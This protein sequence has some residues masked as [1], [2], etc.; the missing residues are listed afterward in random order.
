MRRSE[1]AS[2]IDHTLLGPTATS[3]GV[4]RL[5][6][7]AVELGVTAVCVDLRHAG[8]AR[9]RLVGS[10]VKLC[11]VIGFPQGMTTAAV[12][13]FEAQQAVTC[14]A[15]EIDMVIP[16]GAL[17]EGDFEAVRADVAAVCVVARRAGHPVVVKVILETCFLTDDEKRK[18]AELAVQ[19]GA[20]YVKTSTGFGSAGAT[21][22]DVALLRRVVGPKVGVKA[23]GGIRDTATAI[24]MIQA[25]ASRIGAS[26]TADILSGLD[27][28]TSAA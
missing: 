11:V 21:T 8:L 3:D 14:G 27:E 23:A 22:A 24:A 9:E 12:K 25:G 16:V 28:S 4:E 6:A 17:K 1:L 7:E 2:Y 18:G 5:C 20:D 15:D 10:P 19:A 13:A 26:R